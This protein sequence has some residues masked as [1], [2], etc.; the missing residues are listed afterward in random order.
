[1][2]ADDLQRFFLVVDQN[3]FQVFHFI[4]DDLLKSFSRLL[5]FNRSKRCRYTTA[6]AI[7]SDLFSSFTIIFSTFLGFHPSF[8]LSHF[9]IYN[10]N[11]TIAILQLQITFYNCRNCH[12]LHVNICP[13]Y[14]DIN[15]LSTVPEG[16]SEHPPLHA[17]A[18]KSS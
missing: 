14:T 3:F 4:S 12:Q 17:S 2:H 1:M 5:H 18:T 7:S 6:R 11:C 10:Y 8:P 16:A 15:I 13:A 9:Q